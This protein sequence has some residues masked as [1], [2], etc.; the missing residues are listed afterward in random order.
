MKYFYSF[1][2]GA[3]AGAVVGWVICADWYAPEQ[4]TETAAVEQRQADGSLALERKPDANAKPAHAIPKGGKAERVVS[5]NVQPERADCP[6]CTVDL[7][8]VRMPDD[9]RRV[10]ASSP[11][12]TVLGGLD[13]PIV[14]L[15]VGR[16]YLWAAGI[17]RGIGGEAWGGWVDR[18]FGLLRTG[19][20]A[21]KVSDDRYE[22]RIKLGVR[23]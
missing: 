15:D 12:G 1:L 14:P 10:V 11:T 22:A 20:E 7:T 19:I 18:D 17:S 6:V 21:N 2:I 9:T 13:V 16:D 4:V 5:V 23:F 3:L 8:L